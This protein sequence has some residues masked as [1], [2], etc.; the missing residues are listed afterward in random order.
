MLFFQQRDD[1]SSSVITLAALK[2]DERN[3]PSGNIGEWAHASDQTEAAIEMALTSS[4]LDTDARAQS[5]S[6]VAVNP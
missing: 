6:D 5:R 2:V 1:A 4:D 3:R